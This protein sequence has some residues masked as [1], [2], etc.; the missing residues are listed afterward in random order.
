MFGDRRKRARGKKPCVPGAVK[1]D[2]ARQGRLRGGVPKPAAQLSAAVPSFV[3]PPDQPGVSR[4]VQ[5]G[6][7]P[8]AKPLGAIP[9]GNRDTGS[10]ARTTG[11]GP[12]SKLG[13]FTTP[14]RP[15]STGRWTFH[16]TA[17]VER[18]ATAEVPVEQGAQKRKATS[19]LPQQL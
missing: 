2:L 12:R 13:P 3:P 18:P 11:K 15:S 5:G 9:S 10:P 1:E 8:E 7:K 4:E 14:P 6:P 19:P 17:P 16:P